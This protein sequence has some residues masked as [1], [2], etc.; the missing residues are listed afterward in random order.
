VGFSQGTMMAL[1]VGLKR[2]RPPA[3]I[4][5][6]SGMLADESG[7]ERAAKPGPPILLVHG[8]ADPMIPIAAFHQARDVLARAG[9]TVE[10]HVSRGLAHSIDAPGL[11]LGGAL[12]VRV[13]GRGN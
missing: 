1:E 6:Y 8:D 10:S 4:I 9:F 13:F 12:L 5:G 11:Q 7:L 2:Q 3:A